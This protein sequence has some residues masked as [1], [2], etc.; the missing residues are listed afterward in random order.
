MI[1]LTGLFGFTSETLGTT[2]ALIIS[3][4]KGGFSLFSEPEVG[5]FIIFG[6]VMTGIS[7]VAS[8]A[9]RRRASRKRR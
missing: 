4:L 9:L 3:A 5:V 6:L 1:R 7:F 2:I 8:V